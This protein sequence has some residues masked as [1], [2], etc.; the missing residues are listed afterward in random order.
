MT[1]NPLSYQPKN[2]VASF[3]D[4]Y[5]DTRLVHRPKGR[6]VRVAKLADTPSH[7]LNRATAILMGK[8][9]RARREA[10][11]L[12]MRE[13]SQMAGL[14]N[15]N[16]K[17]YINAIEKATRQEGVRLGTLVALSHA[18]KCQPGDLLPTTEEAVRYGGVNVVA[19]TRLEPS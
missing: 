5:G 7:L 9:I 12:S 11:G 3:V 14:S 15:A 2:V 18:L 17:Q 16:P 10:L 13:L 6:G 1:D 8:K 4:D 19:F